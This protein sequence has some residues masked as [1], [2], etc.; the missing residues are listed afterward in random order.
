MRDGD[1][2]QGAGLQ[3]LE[4]GLS[5]TGVGLGRGAGGHQKLRVSRTHTGKE[6]GKK[7]RKHC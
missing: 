6:G 2:S 3:E 7:E 4:E 5:G 1:V